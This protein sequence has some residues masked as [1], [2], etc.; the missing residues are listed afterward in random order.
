MPTVVDGGAV[1]AII[2]HRGR[3][4][5]HRGIVVDNRRVVIDLGTPVAAAGRNHRRTAHV[6]VPPIV[7]GHVIGVVIVVI[8][9]IAII[10]RPAILHDLVIAWFSH[11]EAA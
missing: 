6:V 2:I 8:R 9:V 11:K 5:V 10:V 4:V 1:I 7:V 3:V